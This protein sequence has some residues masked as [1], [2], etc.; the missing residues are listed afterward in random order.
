MTRQ[1]ANDLLDHVRAGQQV[2]EHEI[3]FALMLTGDLIIQPFRSSKREWT[4][5]Q[6]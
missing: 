3:L 4:E 5:K 1:E 6:S 2:P